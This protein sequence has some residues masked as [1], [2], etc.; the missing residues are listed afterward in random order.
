[1][2]LKTDHEQAQVPLGFERAHTEWLKLEARICV[3]S[4]YRHGVQSEFYETAYWKRVRE[5]VLLRDSYQCFRC[6]GIATQAHH[7]SYHHRGEDHFYPECLVSICRPCHTLVTE[8]RKECAAL[9]SKARDLVP[10]LAHLL[11][12]G[13][14][15]T[16]AED[17]DLTSIRGKPLGPC[18]KC[19]TPVFD[20]GLY[21]ACEDRAGNRQ[22]CTFRIRKIL[23]M[24]EMAPTEI[25]KLLADG[26]TDLLNEFVSLKTSRKFKAFLVLKNGEVKLEIPPRRRTAKPKREKEIPGQFLWDF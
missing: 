18:P 26:K 9:L 17:L 12:N 6:G 10:N 19:G 14:T 3:R 4:K 22:I 23:L 11:V 20:T 8:D 16:S 25:I 21:Y 1:M 24:R 7:L 13:R 2:S 15:A 5:A